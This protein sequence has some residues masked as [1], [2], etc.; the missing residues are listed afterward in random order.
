MYMQEYA[1][2]EAKNASS[3]VDVF[4][5]GPSSKTK[6]GIQCNFK[7]TTSISNET[8]TKERQYE[9][10]DVVYSEC[11]FLHGN[12]EQFDFFGINILLVCSTLV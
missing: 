7:K 10:N 2:G 8:W 3:V 6:K 11:P 1:T 9:M 4:K 12:P 5:N